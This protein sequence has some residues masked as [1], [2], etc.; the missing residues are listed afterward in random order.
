MLAKVSHDL[1]EL[2]CP[3]ESMR[4]CGVHDQTEILQFIAVHDDHMHVIGL[5]AVLAFF[6]ALAFSS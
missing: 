6:A 5:M 1:I 4:I 2:D 3:D